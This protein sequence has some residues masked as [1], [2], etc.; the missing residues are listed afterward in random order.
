MGR[1]ES[2]ISA[3]TAQVG[4]PRHWVLHPFVYGSADPARIPPHL[5]VATTELNSSDLTFYLHDGALIFPAL[6]S[7]ILRSALGHRN[8]R[9]DLIS[10]MFVSMS[11]AHH[12][13]TTMDVHLM[14]ALDGRG[15]TCHVHNRLDEACAVYDELAAMYRTKC[16]HARL[17]VT[18]DMLRHYGGDRALNG[19]TRG[20]VCNALVGRWLVA[21]DLTVL[22]ESGRWQYGRGSV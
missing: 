20:A 12:A 13:A 8:A 16:A 6:S 7:L 22:V 14:R 17:Q 18:H 11:R 9:I 15:L 1:S 21:R 3:S 19:L 4:L 5:A 2:G 10:K